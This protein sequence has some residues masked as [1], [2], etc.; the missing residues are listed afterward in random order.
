MEWNELLEI[1][2]NKEKEGRNEEAIIFF[3]KALQIDP[4]HRES[5]LSLS[6]LYLLTGKP[7]QSLQ[8]LLQNKRFDK[9]KDFLIQLSNTYMT[10]NQFDDAEGVL[11]EAL[12]IKPE[13]SVLNNLGVVSIRRNKSEEAID[14]FTQSLKMDENNLNTWFNLVTFYESL[15]DFNKAKEVIEKALQKLNQRELK[16]KYA[17]LL[18]VTGEFKKALE[19]LDQEIVENPN[20]LIYKVAKARILFQS[21]QYD[22][23][24]E[25]ISD[26][27][28]SETIHPNLKLEFM[29]MSEKC[30]FF[31]QEL[32]KSLDLLDQMLLLSNGNPGYEFR[33]AY[34]LA[35]DKNYKEALKILSQIIGRRNLPPQL[36][37]EAHLL[38]KS[39]E[40]ENWKALIQ[41]FFDES[42]SKEL[43]TQNLLYI[44]ETRRILLPEDGIHFLK[45][46]I[47]AYKSKQIGFDSQSDFIN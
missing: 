32:D 46:A 8:V 42:Q 38:M 33:K 24:Q 12:A 22:L 14:Y 41:F 1:A 30:Y 34:V 28:N 17:Q 2:R 26:I 19:M 21:K 37:H 31:K 47:K 29:E 4:A 44:L 35:V 3:E 6:R 7:I 9:D 18:S 45:M 40:V 25:W 39:I 27:E 43:L 11:K 5:I 16:E 15:S 13:S 20:E 10:L 23:C 36:F